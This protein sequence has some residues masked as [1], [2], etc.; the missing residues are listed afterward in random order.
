M[1]ISAVVD[2]SAAAS[3]PICFAQEFRSH[4]LG[5]ALFKHK[6]VGQ[7]AEH[8]LD[9]LLR[10]T[11]FQKGR[12]IMMPHL[13]ASLRLGRSAESKDREGRKA[14]GGGPRKAAAAAEPR[15]YF[16]PNKLGT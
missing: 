8:Q 5:E 15:R 1:C 10:K 12:V 4:F 2:E 9:D 13:V 16:E 3:P 11:P 6:L 14:P 7:L